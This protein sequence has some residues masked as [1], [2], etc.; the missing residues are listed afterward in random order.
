MNL[1]KQT[2]KNIKEHIK[3]LAKG[4][5]IALLTG[6]LGGFT[7]SLF[8][9]CIDLVTEFR[10]ENTWIIYFLPAG[11]LCIVSLYAIFKNSAPIDTDRVFD[12][13]R[14][15]KKVPLPMLPLIFTGSAISHLVGASVGREGAALQLGGSCG[16][17]IGR[18]FH[19]KPTGV[20][21]AVMSGMSAVFTALFGT[22]VAASVFALEVTLV[23]SMHYGALFP[24]VLSSAVA[25]GVST[26]LGIA[27]VRFAPVLCDMSSPVFA[28]RVIVLSILCAV[29]SIV[30]CKTISTMEK[31]AKR[32]VPNKYLRAFL[33]GALVLGLTWSFGTYDYNGAG[34]HIITRAM[35]GE[36]PYEAFILKIMFTAVSLAAGFKGGEIVP[37][38]FVGSAFGCVAAPIIGMEASTG[39]AIGFISLFC[40]VV[41]CPLASVFLAAEIF[42][43][44]SILMFCLVCAVSYMMSGKG[45]L[46]KSQSILYS[47]LD[48]D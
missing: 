39:A 35:E 32:L 5:L 42:G 27:P 3:A 34:M 17:G 38:F 37:A 26:A 46:Y 13:V 33:G 18:L 40:G 29:L 8:H 6:I 11:S 21:I 12:S 1:L 25:F 22:P 16:Y 28:V 20:R 10:T 23:G 15:D 24:C 41:N 43:T 48:I 14:G 44:D 7:G 45:G 19:L 9:V 30:F 47:K 31:G 4:L 2:I 36:A